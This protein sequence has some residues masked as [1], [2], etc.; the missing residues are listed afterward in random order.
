MGGV[1]GVVEIAMSE[2]RIG[3]DVDD[4]RLAPKVALRRA[5]ELRFRSVEMATVAGDVSASNLS[6]S[7][8]RHL[9]RY[10]EG[11][12]LAF[13]SLVADFPG[14]RLTDPRTVDERVA[15]TL[16]V[17]DLAADMRV[18]VVTAGV[19]ALTHPETGEPSPLAMEALRRIGEAADARG[20]LY[21]LRPSYDSGDRLADV[22]GEIRCPA[23]RVGLDPAAL[24]MSGVDPVRVAERLAGD[25]CLFHARDASIGGRDRGGTEMRL[26]EGEVDFTG[27]L[28]VLEE[29]DFSGDYILR[30]RDSNTPVEDIRAA[31]DVLARLLGDV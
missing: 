20:V 18:P 22:L 11:L 14:I 7:G 28:G 19:G 6:S 4:F 13:S 27:V 15:G 24:V 10:V 2:S 25:V 12:G 30:R 8:R 26:G 9:V 17:I 3:V 21:A 23:L 1:F 5:S 29:M 31:K 16:E